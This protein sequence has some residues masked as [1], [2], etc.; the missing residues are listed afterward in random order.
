M[1]KNKTPGTSKTRKPRAVRQPRSPRLDRRRQAVIDRADA[2][3]KSFDHQVALG[4]LTDALE[5][6]GPSPLPDE[7]QFRL[8]KQRA[9]TYQALGRLADMSQDIRALVRL[10][11]ACSGADLLVEA[12]FIDALAG[13]GSGDYQRI[14]RLA[15][16]AHKTAQRTGDQRL[17]AKSL[18]AIGLA[19][20]NMEE[21]ELSLDS[22]RRAVDLLQQ[23]D[24]ASTKAVC[25]GVMALTP[26][27]DQSKRAEGYLSEALE[28]TRRAGDQ[29]SETRILSLLAILAPDVVAKREYG[30]SA[31]ALSQE[32]HLQEASA[33]ADNH[34]SLLYHN[35]G[36]YG[37]ARH[38]IEEAMEIGRQGLSEN[39]VA[40]FLE[41]QARVLMAAG[42]LSAA[43]A[44]FKEGLALAESIQLRSYLGYLILGL[45]RLSALRGD[46]KTAGKHIRQAIRH[47][48]AVG[49]NIEL[50]VA[51][52]A[53]AEVKL[54]SGDWSAALKLARRAV[55]GLEKVDEANVDFPPQEIWWAYY[56]VLAARPKNRTYLVPADHSQGTLP[57]EADRALRRAFDLARA[58]IEA[59][60]DQGLRRNFW[61]KVAVNRQIVLELARQSTS[62]ALAALTAGASGSD[63][64]EAL[65]R[66]LA[67]GVR[68]NELK[69]PDE[70]IAFIM[71]QLVELSG[72]EQA[73][74]I[75]DGPDGKRSCLAQRGFTAGE[76][77][78]EWAAPIL[79]LATEQP[80]PLLLDDASDQNLARK[81]RVREHRL[82][83]LCVP[84]T[85]HA[86]ASGWLYVD[87]HTRVRPLHPGRSGLD[88]DVRQ[89]GVGRSG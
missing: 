30:E 1:A 2:A 3:Y 33:L 26:G 51:Q 21:T 41:T 44:A 80:G 15:K 81:A 13:R 75:V 32:L 28:L 83:V 29:R 43:E 39:H 45:G 58:E 84:L 60:S 64:K 49:A 70:L 71:D 87:T 12:S 5:W 82:S 6:P 37:A 89:S 4:A 11:S 67:I 88:V 76:D 63:I 34:L 62:D 23:V 20:S 66:M 46:L 40:A 86:Y 24:D 47:F 55:L 35:I 72:A 7:T 14:L 16:R 69:E 31:L 61:N 50:A 57:A 36:L 68:M 19:Y 54:Q 10:A 85:S 59:V 52:S 56:R 77:P 74:L 9:D 17:V 38:Y 22:L 53:L 48:T 8:L 73:A 65:R 25:L 42:D 18:A 27:V 78:V 79:R